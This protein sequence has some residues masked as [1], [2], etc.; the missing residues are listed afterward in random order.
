MT[1]LMHRILESRPAIP[2]SEFR[3]A[4]PEAVD[5]IRLMMERRPD[6]R[7]ASIAAARSALERLKRGLAL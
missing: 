1:D 5:V 3:G 2:L 6:N 7:Y 4:P